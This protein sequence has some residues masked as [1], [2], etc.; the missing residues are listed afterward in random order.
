MNETLVK[1][2]KSG[3]KS[4]AVSSCAP[5]HAEMF[6]DLI[7]NCIFM[8]SHYFKMQ[9]QVKEYLSLL[10]N[11]MMNEILVKTEENTRN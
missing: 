3:E 10:V 4:T 7:W 1:R 9:L 6:F 11:I 8:M 2:D 5:Y